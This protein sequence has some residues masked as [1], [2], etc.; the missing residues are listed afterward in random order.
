M[1]FEG[2]QIRP[3]D[4]LYLSLNLSCRCV[5]LF[6]YTQQRLVRALRIDLF[7]SLLRQDISFFDTAASGDISSRLTSGRVSLYLFV[8]LSL[9]RSLSFSL[10]LSLSLPLSL[11]LCLSL[12]LS[13]PPLSQQLQAHPVQADPRR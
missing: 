3:G 5:F 2:A 10:S 9:C 8:F 7:R 11:C 6:G 12:S 13:P 4:W 1:L